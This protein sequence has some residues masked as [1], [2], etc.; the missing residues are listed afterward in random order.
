MASS[1]SQEFPTG[2][3]TCNKSHWIDRGQ[4][5]CPDLH[6]P[7]WRQDAHRHRRLPP[8]PDRAE[9]VAA[10]SMDC[11]ASAPLAAAGEG[12]NGRRIQRRVP[13]VDP[14]P[15]S[16]AS[17]TQASRETSFRGGKRAPAPI[18]RTNHPRL[19]KHSFSAAIALRKPHF[20]NEGNANTACATKRSWPVG[21]TIWRRKRRD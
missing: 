14:R 10:A 7:I 8:R 13:L 15:R 17:G 5:T 18:Q 16:E 12:G 20:R 11:R 19:A 1:I 6:L 4:N 9:W 2:R 3:Q 21:P